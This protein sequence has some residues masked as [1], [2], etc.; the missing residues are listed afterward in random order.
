MAESPK[1]STSQFLFL[2]VTATVNAATVT[3]T[4]IAQSTAN[5]HRGVLSPTAARPSDIDLKPISQG[6]AV[7]TAPTPIT[8]SVAII[9][10][11]L[12][13]P[14]RKQRANNITTRSP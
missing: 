13:W 2:P 3:P 6:R 5:C 12:S 8:I 1:A 10:L 4:W 11:T 7:I 14:D 9:F